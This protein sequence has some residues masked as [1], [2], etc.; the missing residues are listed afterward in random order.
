MSPKVQLY[1]TQSSVSIGI[2]GEQFVTG[3]TDTH[4]A[5]WSGVP[6]FEYMTFIY[7]VFQVVDY[8]ICTCVY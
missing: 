8:E 1:V 4:C 3:L 7:M 6:C 5:L 2:T